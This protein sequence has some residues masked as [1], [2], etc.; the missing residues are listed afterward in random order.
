MLYDWVL[1]VAGVDDDGHAGLP[2]HTHQSTLSVPSNKTVGWGRSD[3]VGQQHSAVKP[4]VP[5]TLR[6]SGHRHFLHH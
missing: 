3:L 4:S 2:L 5:A 1:G 6:V